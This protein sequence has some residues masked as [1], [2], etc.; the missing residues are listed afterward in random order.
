MHHQMAQKSYLPGVA[1]EVYLDPKSV[2]HIQQSLW[3]ASEANRPR[4]LAMKN[5]YLAQLLEM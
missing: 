4:F 3:V 1:S 2:I 5:L